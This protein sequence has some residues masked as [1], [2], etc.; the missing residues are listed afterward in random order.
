[1]FT[2]EGATCKTEHFVGDSLSCQWSD[3][4]C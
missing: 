1:M 3:H 4:C 2:F